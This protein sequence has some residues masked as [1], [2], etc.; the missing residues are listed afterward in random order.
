M[1]LSILLLLTSPTNSFFPLFAPAASATIYSFIRLGQ[2]LRMDQGIKAGYLTAEI[3]FLQGIVYMPY[4]HLKP[5]IHIFPAKIIPL[6]LELRKGK[7]LK[8]IP[9]L[10][11]LLLF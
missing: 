7:V 10:L 2:F 1:V 8:R 11:F 3:A 5:E 9:H 6:G 4:N